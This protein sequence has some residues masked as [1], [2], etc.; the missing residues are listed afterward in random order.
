M[1]VRYVSGTRLHRASVLP[2]FVSEDKFTELHIS[3]ND[4]VLM[5]V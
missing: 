3:Q 2:I 1:K 4:S 5:A